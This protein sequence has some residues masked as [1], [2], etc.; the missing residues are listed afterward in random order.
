MINNNDKCNHNDCSKKLKLTDFPCKCD[1]IFCKL[2]RLPEKHECTY[3][4]KCNIS[5]KKKIEELKC[6]SAKI[7][8]I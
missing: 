3:N 7:Q 8:K 6:V 5:R 2:H 4:Y 1:K